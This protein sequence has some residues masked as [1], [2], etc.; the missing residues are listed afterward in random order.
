MVYFIR[1]GIFIIIIFV[2]KNGEYVKYNEI[3]NKYEDD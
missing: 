1:F 3:N 2:N